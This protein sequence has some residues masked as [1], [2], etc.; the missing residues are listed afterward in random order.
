[1]A[2]AGPL[3]NFMVGI[4]FSLAIRFFSLPEMLASFFGIIAFYNFLLCIFNLIPVPPLDGSHILF[5]FLPDNTP[6]RNFLGQ[7]GPLIL[8][9]L[10]FYGLGWIPF[11]AEKFLYFFAGA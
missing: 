1:V 4:I 3:T 9:F 10:I 5:S 11:L 7:Y 2:L 6:I 8:L